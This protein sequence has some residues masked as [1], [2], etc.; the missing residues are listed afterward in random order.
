MAKRKKLKSIVSLKRQAQRYFNKYII[1]RD[2]ISDT[3]FQCIAC[4]KRYTIDKAQ[5]G[6][7]FGTKKYN[8]MRFNEDNCH[9]ECIY[10]NAFNHESLINYTLSIQVKLKQERFLRLLEESYIKKPEFTRIQLEEIINK[11]KNLT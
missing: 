4:H 2:R 3:E 5:A 11:Y 1:K 9:I 6:H 7:F 8:W 10:C